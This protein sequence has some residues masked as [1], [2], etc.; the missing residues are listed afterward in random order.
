[1]REEEKEIEKPNEITDIAEKVLDFNKQ[2]QKGQGLKII[3]PNQMLGRLPI[4]LSQLKVGN[5]SEK[6]KDEITL[7]L[8]SL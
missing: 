2:K 1:M 3:T 4:S 8:Y 7:L 6:L 5:S